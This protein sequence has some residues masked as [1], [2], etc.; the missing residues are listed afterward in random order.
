MSIKKIE[1]IRENIRELH[2]QRAGFQAQTRSREEVRA[3]VEALVSEWHAEARAQHALNLRLLA[4]GQL[5]PLLTEDKLGAAFVMMLG[6]EQVVSALLADVDAVPEGTDAVERHAQITA[7]ESELDALEAEE[8]A[9]IVAAEDAGERVTRRADARPEIVLGRREP[10]LAVHPRS[11]H[12]LGL[13]EV[14]PTRRRFAV[15][16]TFPG[17]HSP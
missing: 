4:T 14:K 9:L 17:Q 13:G 10:A 6:K 1:V 5:R 7:I 8:E 11:P 2:Q 16:P 3:Y 12:Y 15:Y